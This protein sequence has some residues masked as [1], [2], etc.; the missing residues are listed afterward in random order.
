MELLDLCLDVRGLFC[1]QNVLFC[2]RTCRR[3]ELMG[4][5]EA[6]W[7]TDASRMCAS[8]NPRYELLM[9]WMEELIK[10]SLS[11]SFSAKG[12]DLVLACAQSPVE[13][14]IGSRL[15]PRDVGQEDPR[16]RRQG[17]S[18]NLR[19]CTGRY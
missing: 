15:L 18:P 12:N 4:Y 8:R 14:T 11:V 16:L 5:R 6:S 19:P 17:S 7:W 10:R 13:A 2:F 9:G 3:I 1:V